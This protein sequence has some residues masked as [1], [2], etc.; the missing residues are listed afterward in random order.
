MTNTLDR[1]A[2]TSDRLT[3]A[4][5]LLVESIERL[6]SGDDWRAML[7]TAAR[8][9]QYSAN[10]VFLIVA[11][12][13]EATRVAG[14]KTWQS[15]GRQVRKGER[16]IRILAPCK[17]KRT[18]VDQVTGEETT[19]VGIRGFTTVGVFDIAQTDGDDIADVRPELLAGE[20]PA[21]LW[22]HLA[23]QVAAAGFTLERGHCGGANG[24]TVWGARVV[25][26]RADVDDAQ[27]VKTLAHELAHVML[28]ESSM[29]C[30]GI[31]EVEAE[32]VAHLVCQLS[33]VDTAG[34]SF[35]YVARW[36]G[37]DV[38]AIRKTADLVIK[39]ARAI[40]DTS[41]DA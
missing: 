3:E 17:Y 29:T 6:T 15:L 4:H 30:R 18:D 38:D 37:G 22:D 39:T 41:A 40:V 11:Q 32:S 12:A 27:A 19:K 13:P 24:H 26:V 9:H 16:S 35:P 28:H 33:G 36:A 1:S 21:G 25:R 10:N 23:A 2:T 8:F 31:A 7:D 34:Y 14:Y 5:A 20:A